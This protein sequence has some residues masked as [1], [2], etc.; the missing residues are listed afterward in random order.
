MNI[1]QQKDKYNLRQDHLQNTLKQPPLI[2]VTPGTFDQSNE[3]KL[4]DQQ[5]EEDND[6]DK[7]KIY[8]QE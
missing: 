2:F 1:D 8:V 6:T 3:E 4:P 7:D 5:K